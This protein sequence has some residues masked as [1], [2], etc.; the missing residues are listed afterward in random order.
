LNKNIVFHFNLR[1]FSAIFIQQLIHFLKSETVFINI[2]IIGKLAK[3][4]NWYHSL[5]EDFN[6]IEKLIQQNPTSKILCV[7]AQLYQNAGAN[8]VQQIAYALAHA[9]EYF[10]KFGGE[11]A[12]HISF[13]FSIGSNFFFEI[14]KLRAFRYLLNLILNEYQCSA[15]AHIFTEPSYRNKTISNKKLNLLRLTTESLSAILGGANTIANQPFNSI[16]ED[17]SIN[18]LLI[19]QESNL[20]NNYIEIVNDQYYIEALTKQIAEKALQIF[21]E[22]E[23]GGGFLA[24]LKQGVIQRKIAENAK[25]EQD[26]FNLGTKILVGSNKYLHQDEQPTLNLQPFLEK[27]S[28]KTLIIPIIPKRLSEKL[29]QKKLKNEA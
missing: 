13:N 16:L 21:K 23:K 4:G 26:E 3:T 5:N 15:E 14:A 7:N 12:N 20:L 27:K 8:T 29:E 28:H 11:I 25:K 6:S 17:N 2:D 1:F 24:Q 22:I 18:Q 9:N 10:Q 19:L